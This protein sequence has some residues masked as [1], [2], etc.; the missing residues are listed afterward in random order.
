MFGTLDTLAKRKEFGA[1][2]QEHARLWVGHADVVST[3]LGR[4][5]ARYK[6][7]LLFGVVHK[8]ARNSSL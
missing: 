7:V 3:N 5:Q 1:Q 2:D 4:C 8:L 6:H